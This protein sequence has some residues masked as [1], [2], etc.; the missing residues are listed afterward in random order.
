MK[1]DMPDDINNVSHHYAGVFLV[2]ESGDIL[3][4]LRDDKPGI[5]MPGRVGTFGGAMEPED[6]T[7]L[8]GALR[9]LAEETNLEI[10]PFEVVHLTTSIGWR[11]RTEEW[12]GRHIFYMT[13]PDDAVSALEIYEGQ[14]WTVITGSDD[15]RLIDDWCEF[16]QLLREKLGLA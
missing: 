5:D 10:D 4:Q 2:T 12:E 13:I 11:V 1:P 6:E 8:H 3:G 7:P 15:P 14:G 9:E 16:V